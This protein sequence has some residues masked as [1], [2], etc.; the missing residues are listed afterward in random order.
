MAYGPKAAQHGT[1]SGRTNAA[2]NGGGLAARERICM[3]II[4]VCTGGAV[5]S[6]REREGAASAK[7]RGS[8]P[9][10]KLP[11]TGRASREREVHALGKSTWRAGGRAGQRHERN[12][13]VWFVPAC[14]RQ[15]QSGTQRCL[16]PRARVNGVGAALGWAPCGA[17]PSRDTCGVGVPTRK[18]RDVVSTL[19]STTP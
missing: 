16:V 5:G 12:G 13:P 7:G 3:H 11:K 14:G 6:G 8:S 17:H 15:W 1:A 19:I 10:S 18:K 2:W 4:I 9:F